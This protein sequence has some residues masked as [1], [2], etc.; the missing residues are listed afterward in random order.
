M[1][2]M[3]SGTATQITSDDLVSGGLTVAWVL[4]PAMRRWPPIRALE[5]QALAEL[6]TGRLVPDVQPFPLKDA[7]AAHA[8]LETRATRGKVVLVP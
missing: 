3:A 6:A 7:A 5:E 1:F 8:A 4:G 2:G